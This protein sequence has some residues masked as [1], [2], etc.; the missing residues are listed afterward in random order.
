MILGFTLTRGDCGK[1]DQDN[2]VSFILFM[3]SLK[4]INCLSSV[5]DRHFYFKDVRLYF[6]VRKENRSEFFS[7]LTAKRF[8]LIVSLVSEITSSQLLL[9]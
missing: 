1:T 2:L 8:I 9:C 7:L 5:K 3:P 6:S 4:A